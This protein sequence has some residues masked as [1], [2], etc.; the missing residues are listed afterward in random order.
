MISKSFE[1]YEKS[2]QV[3]KYDYTFNSNTTLSGH[4]ISLGSEIECMA[5]AISG[6]KSNLL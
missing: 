5:S 6:C 1:V 3:G 2:V 4:D